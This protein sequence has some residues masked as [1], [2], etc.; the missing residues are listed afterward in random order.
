LNGSRSAR[1][2]ASA[3]A[4]RVNHQPT[5]NAAG[6]SRQRSPP[7]TAS[8]RQTG[9]LEARAGHRPQ[10]EDERDEP[11]TDRQRV[12][13]QRVAQQRGARCLSDETVRKRRGGRG[14]ARGAQA[15]TPTYAPDETRCGHTKSQVR[16]TV[17]TR[18][19]RRT[20]RSSSP[21]PAA[22]GAG[23]T[24][25][26]SGPR[27]LRA[28]RRGSGRGRPSTTP[29]VPADPPPSH[30]STRRAHPTPR[31][32]RTHDRFAGGAIFGTTARVAR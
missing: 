4:C 19:A 31:R 15:L 26:R 8:A 1:T 2:R 30:A 11:A 20:R 21:R 32:A 23:W 29:S 3:C 16:C 6:T 5:P 25:C 7:A 27:R 9:G 22:H 10:S 17:E 12:A 14:A 13:Q 18:H 24:R 28:G